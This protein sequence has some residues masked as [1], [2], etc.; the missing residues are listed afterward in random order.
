MN[1]RSRTLI[2]T[3][4]ACVAF[5]AHAVPVTFS[6]SGGNAAG[7]QATVDAFRTTLG[8]LNANVAGSFGSGRREINWDGGGST[9]TSLGPTPFDVFLVT[10]GSRFITPGSGF[11]QARPQIAPTSVT[12]FASQTG[13]VA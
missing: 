6:A 5:G 2:A 4:G 12:H 9:A 13:S 1:N 8:P 7:I 10:R 11:V 3:L